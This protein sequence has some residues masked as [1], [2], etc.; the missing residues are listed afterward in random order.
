M[1]E[2]AVGTR[3][4]PRADA[5]GAAATERFRAWLRARDLPVTR[6]RLAIADILLTADRQL[7]AEEVA[8]ELALRGTRVGTA[9]VYRTLDVLVES[10]LLVERDF[11]EGFRRFEPV[12]G[13]SAQAQLR[14]LSCGRREEF[15]DADLD[16]LIARA[17]EARGFA[18]G[19]HRLVVHGTCREC[20]ATG[21]ERDA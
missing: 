19:R 16:R 14:C 3:A 20:G 4:R 6:Q 1:A 10:G 5:A 18:F 11:R 15:Q 8:H 12:R 17:V 9:T 21:A 2:H 13:A 7:A